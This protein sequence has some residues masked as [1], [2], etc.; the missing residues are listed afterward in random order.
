M[1]GSYDSSRLPTTH[2]VSHSQDCEDKIFKTFKDKNFRVL[3][4][5]YPNLKSTIMIKIKRKPIKPM[6]IVI[7][8]DQSNDGSK[9]FK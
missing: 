6:I 7:G 5:P 3:Q 1:I 8:I 4:P 9:K 2:K